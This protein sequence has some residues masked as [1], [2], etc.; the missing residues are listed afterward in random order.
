MKIFEANISSEVAEF[1]IKKLNR[2][3]TLETANAK[4][5]DACGI[6]YFFDQKDEFETLKE[7]IFSHKSTAEEP[8]RTEFGDFQ[9]NLKLAKEI[10]LFL[11]NSSVNP[12]II[13]EPTCG[14]GSFI[15][16]SLQTFKRVEKIIGVE[17]YKPY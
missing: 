5:F 11:N 8:D 1:F 7:I 14:K 9:T 13:V 2:T 10:S 4:M 17:I 12:K 16:A 15:I 6:K 3:T